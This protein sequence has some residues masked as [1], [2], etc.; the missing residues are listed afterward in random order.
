[1]G[2]RQ[3]DHRQDARGVAHLAVQ[4]QFAQDRR[5]RD[6][7]GGHLLGRG[8]DRQGDGQVV[9]RA[10]LLQVGGGQADHD[11]LERKLAAGVADAARTRSF[12]SCTAVSGRPDDEKAGQAR[13]DIYFDLDQCAVE[14]SDGTTANFRQAHARVISYRGIGVAA[15]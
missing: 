10:F 6:Q 11:P 7:V 1:M 13:T 12:A 8:Q 4:P 3:R 5:S 15:S 2:L 9:G 14:A